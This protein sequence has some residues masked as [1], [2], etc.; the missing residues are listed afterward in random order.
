MRIRLRFI[1]SAFIMFSMAFSY[2]QSIRV[3]TYNIKF[4]DKRDSVNNWQKRK[5][6]VIGL[7]NY[8]QPDIIGTQEGLHHQLEDIKKGSAGYDYL[9]AGRDDGRSKGEYCAIFYSKDRF[10]VVRSGTFWLSLSPDKPSKSWDAALP[11]ICTWAQ[12]K[13]IGQD[14]SFFIF[15][16]HFDHVGKKAREESVRLIMNR[17]QEIA[18]K[19]PVVLTGD[20]NFTPDAPAYAKA[21]KM[22][23]DTR[24][25]P[26]ITP[27]GPEATFNGFNFLRQPERR[28]DY[29]FVNDRIRALTYACITDSKNMK[30]PSDHFPVVTDLK[31][32]GLVR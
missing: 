25:V 9:G 28:I 3:M 27:Y 20:F 17:I 8:H 5:A 21:I 13:A 6:E 30:Y 4:D 12:M 26:G 10:E 1:F 19:A 11:R 24:E 29:I 7:L 16:T 2:G 31:I 15:N 23:R 22:M 32:H 18:N 14:S